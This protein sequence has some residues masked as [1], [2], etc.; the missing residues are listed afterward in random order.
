MIASF[1]FPILERG[2][3]IIG[4]KSRMRGGMPIWVGRFSGVIAPREFA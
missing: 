2:W 4:R 1:Y 3:A